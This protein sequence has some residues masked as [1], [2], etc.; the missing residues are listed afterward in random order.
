M[1][2][3][4][5]AQN[6]E[7]VMLWR[8]LGHVRGG[9]FIDVGA[10]WPVQD[11][12]TRLFKDRGWRGINVEPNPALFRE[13]VEDRP[14]DINLAVAVSDQRATL[15]M[16]IVAETGLSTLSAEIGGLYRSE[17]R[18]VES[19]T[20]DVVPLAELWDQHVPDDQAVHF[21]KVDVEGY[22]GQVLAGA[23]W[24]KHRPWVVVVEAT[25]P[26]SQVAS[27]ETWETNLIDARYRFAY[28]DGLNR[29][30]VAHEHDD[31]MESFRYPPNV[32]DGFITAA[33]DAAERRVA[34][35]EVFGIEA[36]HRAE[37]AEDSLLR[38]ESRASWLQS[39]WDAAVR[40]ATELL[41]A[42]GALDA[43][44]GERERAL[45]STSAQLHAAH[46]GAAEVT[47]LNHGLVNEVEGLRAEAE[48]QY[49]QITHLDSHITAMYAS[50][51]W[52]FARPV[53]LAGSVA[54][55]LRL[56]PRRLLRR[57]A[58][59]APEALQSLSSAFTDASDDPVAHD[60]EIIA[61][62]PASANHVLRLLATSHA[63]GEIPAR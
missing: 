36:V 29:F 60:A 15:E 48:R 53:R 39:E 24:Q 4:S 8:A 63:D 12:V 41:R 35:A 38:A 27:H 26:T 47:R 45:T 42:N 55:H 16:D 1:T 17:G 33:H 43:L 10:A 9:F 61:D 11:S 32:F 57:G 56:L 18:E 54:R 31:L 52:R 20:V 21:L 30:Y 14:D 40:S 25:R 50:A 23:D 2:I 28:A 51:S 59:T 58:V 7:D 44:L 49:A 3:V 5:Y 22:E 62:M 13:L 19:L 37:V 46:V 6:Y 34:A